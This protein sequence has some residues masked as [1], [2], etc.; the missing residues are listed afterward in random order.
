MLFKRLADNRNQD[1]LANQLRRKRFAIFTEMLDSL[2]RPVRILDVGGTPNFW[3]QMGLT[4]VEDIHVSLINIKAEP[5]TFK[6]FTSVSG[7]AR[8]MPQ[9]ANGS[10][11]IV[12]SNSVIE[13]VGDYDDQRCMAQEIQRISQ[14]YFVQTP[15]RYF[16]VEPH[17]VFPLFQFLPVAIRVWL[18][19]HFKL[20]W[21]NR[22]TDPVKARQAVE[23]IQL[24]SKAQFVALFPGAT[25]YEEKLY[26]LT[27][28][29]IVYA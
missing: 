20:G 4:D 28:S 25:L 29:F 21:Y 14:H 27:K 17:F 12:F 5:V 6:N 26:G 22:Y 13:H 3:R 19:T 18:I 8:A 2:P 7:D 11:D 1:S 9:Y 23:S 16:P 15:N 10:F 24:L